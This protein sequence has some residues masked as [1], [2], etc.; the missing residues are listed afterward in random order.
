VK[1]RALGLG[2]VAALLLGCGTTQKLTVTSD[3]DGAKISFVKMGFKTQGEN[4]PKEE[5]TEAAQPIG[6]TPLEF[7]FDP[8]AGSTDAQTKQVLRGMLV[9]EKDG[10]RAEEPVNFN[11]DHLPAKV[12]LHLE[13]K[14]AA[15][16]P[17]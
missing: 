10:Q 15:P 5:F 3:P 11:P 7:E 6:T 9:A 16:T 2:F 14:P 12:M 13:P 1:T 17:K 4:G 8:F